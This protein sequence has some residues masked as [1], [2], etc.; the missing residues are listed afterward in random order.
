MPLLVNEPLLHTEALIPS[1]PS[2]FKYGL[3]AQ[4]PS[5]ASNAN[6]IRDHGK[7]IGEADV[8]TDLAGYRAS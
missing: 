7:T 5:A 4:S 3:D 2:A 1:L 6:F 8:S